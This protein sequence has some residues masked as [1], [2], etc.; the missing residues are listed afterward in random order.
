MILSKREINDNEQSFTIY[1]LNSVE[2]IGSVEAISESFKILTNNKNGFINATVLCNS[3][4][5]DF[6]EYRKSDNFQKLKIRLKEITDKLHIKVRGNCYKNEYSLP[7]IDMEYE[8][9]NL[10]IHETFKDDLNLLSGIY[11]HPMLAEDIA[12]WCSEE[13]EVK[14]SYILYV[15]NETNDNNFRNL[16]EEYAEIKYELEN[17]NY[18]DLKYQLENQLDSYTNQQMEL[19]IL[20]NKMEQI[21]AKLIEENNFLEEQNDRFEELNKN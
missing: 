7:M 16:R 6:E 14:L 3:L 12:K 21:N 8:L 1:K 20:T 13:T 18:E 19:I 5:K 15:N 17:S 10:Q 4:G 2:I 11:V 9:T